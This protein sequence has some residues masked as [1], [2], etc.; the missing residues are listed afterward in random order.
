MLQSI[1]LWSALKPQGVKNMM[2]NVLLYGAAIL[3]LGALAILATLPAHGQDNEVTYIT[4]GMVCDTKEQV[5]DIIETWRDKG[6]EEYKKKY[7]QY[8]STI[9]SHM[10]STCAT[11]SIGVYLEAKLKVYEKMKTHLGVFDIHIV[12]GKGHNSGRTFHIG[13]MIPVKTKPEKTI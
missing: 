8:F 1:A 13:Y 5:F 11:G 10:E 9:N 6:F 12:R 3:M 4:D 7:L 2:K